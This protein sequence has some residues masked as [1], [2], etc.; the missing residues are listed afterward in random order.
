MEKN[1]PEYTPGL[2]RILISGPESS[3]KTDL[4]N[5]LA[6][7]FRGVAVGEYAR[8]YV[9]G[10][11]RPYNIKDV[12]H[13]ARH[14]ISSLEDEYPGTDWIFFDTWLIITRVWFDVVYKT[15][16][17]WLDDAIR[18]T[19]FDLVLLC[20]P[21]LPWIPDGVRENGG[22]QRFKLFEQY[23]NE[24]ERFGMEWEV[25]SG[26]GAERFKKAEEIIQRK[27]GYG[28]I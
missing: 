8:A 17:A 3:G 21:D 23:K 26:T 11:D 12:E 25:V 15:V 2:K 18:G 10:L 28:A 19:H 16:P 4:V 13:I 22:K 20:A 5:Y 9:E 6:E 1:T 27:T 14:Q 7:R 24:F